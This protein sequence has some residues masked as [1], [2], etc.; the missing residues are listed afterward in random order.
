MQAGRAGRGAGLRALAVAGLAAA[1]LT[2]GCGGGGSGSSSGNGLEKTHLTVGAL[3]LIDNAPLFLAIKRGFFAQQGLTVKPDLIAQSTLALPDLLH[4]TVD[5]I[6]GGNYVS[7]FEGQAQGTFSV[8][9]LAPAS[10]CTAS[11][12]SILALPSSHITGPAGLKGKTIAVNLTNNIQTLMAGAL[13][14]AAGVPASSVKFVAIP[15]PTMA[16]ALKAHRVDAIS[17]VEPFLSGAEQTMGA[18][19]VMSSCSGPVAHFPLSGYFAT[20]Q[21]TQ[22][23]PKTARAFQR[24][25]AKAQ[26]L[27]ER[28]PAAVKAILPTYSK[29]TAAAAQH[30]ALTTYPATARAADLQ[31]VANLMLSG[32]L[33][34]S[35][36][37]VQSM[38]FH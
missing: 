19:P 7:Y 21:W 16:S 37:S 36:L 5:I 33:L 6:G 17:A 30:I 29:I 4:G 35:R 15:F 23:Y 27:A 20:Q 18:K 1:L 2:A 28:D 26:A 34:K 8:R 13:L 25:M 14:K 22:K 9:V 10:T 12:F 11:S 3:P 24:A 31:R 32:G 38:L